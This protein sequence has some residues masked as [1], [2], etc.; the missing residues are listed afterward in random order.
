[1]FFVKLIGAKFLYH[2]KADKHY[3]YKSNGKAGNVY[4]KHAG[5]VSDIS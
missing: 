3:R 2:E 1:M 5:I 4:Q